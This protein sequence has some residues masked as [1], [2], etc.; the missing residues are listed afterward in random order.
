[1]R[2]RQIKQQLLPLLAATDFTRGL[3]KIL[4]L[5][6]RQVINPLIGTFYHG[7]EQVRW[8]AIA[9]AGAVIARMADENL[10]DA[11]VVMRRLIWSLNDESGG[12]GWGAPEAMGEACA[13]HAQIAEEFGAIVFSYIWPDG[14]FLEH[15]ILQ[16]GS[17]WAVGRLAHARPECASC[18]GPWLVPFLSAEHGRHRA[19]AAWAA[20]AAGD[21]RLVLPLKNLIEDE[22]PV[23]IYQDARPVALTVGQWARKALSQITGP[24]PD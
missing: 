6:G 11:R 2:S 19:L 7:D 4:A 14:N 5:P 1:M 10:E 15:P 18:V 24:S 17:L 8:R 16:Y 22:T 21:H 23:T 13:L 12:I 9:A 20:G 3:E